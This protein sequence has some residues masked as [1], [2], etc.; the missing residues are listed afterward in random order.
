MKSAADYLWSSRRTAAASLKVLAHFQ[1]NDF[2]DA[3]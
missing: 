2:Q 1:R 3:S